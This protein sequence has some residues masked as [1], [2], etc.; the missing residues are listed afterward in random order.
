MEAGGFVVEFGSGTFPFFVNRPKNYQSEPLTMGIEGG[1][2]D[3]KAHAHESHAV[4]QTLSSAKPL[5]TKS[6]EDR[7]GDDLTSAL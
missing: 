4:D 6:N 3:P 7:S 1:S 5:D 2:Y